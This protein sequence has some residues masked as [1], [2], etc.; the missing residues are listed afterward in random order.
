MI[1]IETQW[2]MY[3]LEVVDIDCPIELKKDDVVDLYDD[4]LNKV[5]WQAK[6]ILVIKNNKYKIQRVK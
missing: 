3:K 4:K 1:T 6:V 5:Y 2:Y